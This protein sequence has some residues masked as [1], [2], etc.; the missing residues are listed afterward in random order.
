MNKIGKHKNQN[1]PVT[2]LAHTLAVDCNPLFDV[3]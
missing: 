2:P 1:I 3:P